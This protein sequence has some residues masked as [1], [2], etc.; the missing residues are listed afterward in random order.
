MPGAVSQDQLVRYYGA[1]DIL[2]LA[3]SR[4]G[5][6]NV[7]LESLACGTPVVATPVWG[8]PEIVAAKEA[9]YLTANRTSEAI[10]ASI[11]NLLSDLPSRR[12]TRHYAEMFSWDDTTYGQRKIFESIQGY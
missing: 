3:S 9:G 7:L 8:T 12:D 11:N 4:E 6:A 1:A 10:T 5:W 2:V